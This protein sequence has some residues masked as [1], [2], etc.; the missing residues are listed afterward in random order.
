[1]LPLSGRLAYLEVPGIFV[2]ASGMQPP[3]YRSL[4]CGTFCVLLS[5]ST[6]SLGK[7]YSGTLRESVEEEDQEIS[8]GETLL[9]RW[10]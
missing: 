6:T 5:R 8:G 2:K 10:R 9:L 3:P 7:P 4:A 1:L